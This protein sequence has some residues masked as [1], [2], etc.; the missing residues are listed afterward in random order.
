MRD[1]INDGADFAEV[2]KTFPN[3]SEDDFTLF[4]ANEAKPEKKALRVWGKA[5]HGKNVAPHNLGSRG[6]P[7]KQQRWKKEDDERK[8]PS[9]YDKITDPL[10]R[11]FIRAHY[12][13]NSLTPGE[14][15]NN[16]KVKEIMDKLLEEE[17][18]ERKADRK[19]TRLNSSHSGESRMPSSA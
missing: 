1:M 2:N 8:G 5:A 14:L 7:G 15:A 4:K 17:E 3:I 6:Y 9:I 13:E 11:Q 19:S 16:A 18:K 12:K 10:A